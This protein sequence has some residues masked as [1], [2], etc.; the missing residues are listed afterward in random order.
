MAWDEGDAR[1]I[2]GLLDALGQQVRGVE[3]VDRLCQPSIQ[4]FI[5]DTSPL[6]WW[7]G[8]RQRCESLVNPNDVVTTTATS[9]NIQLN[10]GWVE[11]MVA[12]HSNSKTNTTFFD[13]VIAGMTISAGDSIISGY[14]DF[15]GHST[16]VVEHEFEEAVLGLFVSIW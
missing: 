5:D 8:A 6:R 14:H 3:V 1:R 9:V 7:G 10:S 4:S 12:A 15:Y 13:V 16:R 2:A 11:A